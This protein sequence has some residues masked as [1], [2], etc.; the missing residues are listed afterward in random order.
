MVLAVASKAGAAGHPMLDLARA[1]WAQAI[2][3][4]RSMRPPPRGAHH[5]RHLT[6]AARDIGD[7][8]DAVRLHLRGADDA[9]TNVVMGRLRQGFEELRHAAAALPGFEMVGFAQGCCARHPIRSD[10]R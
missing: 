9:A 3:S 10:A 4:V 7:A 6:L 2:E 8:L 5:H 1:A